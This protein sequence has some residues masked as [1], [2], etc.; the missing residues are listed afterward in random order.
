VGPGLRRARA[1]G[2]RHPETAAALRQLGLLRFQLG[3]YEGAAG[4][5]ERSLAILLGLGSGQ[6][7]KVADGHNNLGE[8]ARVRDRL[9]SAEAHFRL[10]LEAARASL[11]DA[12]PVRL[13]LANNL[14]GL[15]KDVGRLDEAEPLLESG[16]AT[17]EASAADPEALATAR[18]NLAEVR[19]LQGRPA[20][21]APLYARALEEARAALGA[22]H[23]GLVPFLNQAA[24]CEQE[25]G[26]F[27]RA[28]SLFL[29]TGTILRATLGPEH[30][31]LA[32]NLGDLARLRLAAGRPLEADT[33]LARALG[34]RERSL[35]P[36]HP[37]VALIL[38]DRARVRARVEPG[39]EAAPIA[40]ALAILDSS[41]AY[42]DARLDAH[43][44]RAEGEARRGELDAAIADMAVALAWMDSL[45]ARRGGG[46]ETR[47][48]FVSARLPLVDRM[49]DWQLE[50]GA[51]DAALETHERGRARVLLDQIAASGVDLRAGIPPAVL[52]P[53][54]D[55]ERA[56]EARLA[57]AHRGIQ[58][59]RGDPS[60][61]PRER[62]ETLAAL[63]ARRDSA[64]L[65][66]AL[67]RRRIED[68]SPVWRGV[69]SAEGRIPGAA[70]LQRTIV[71]R[72]G[73]LLVYHVGSR[74]GHVFVVPPRGRIEALPL[75]LDPE[76]AAILGVPAGPLADSTLER[77][78]NGAPARDGRAA[79]PGISSLLGGT[80]A[81]GFVALPLRSAA[82][83]DSF[84]LRLNALWR[85]VVPE[86]LRARLRAAR[87]AVVVPDGALHQVAFEALVTRPRGRADATRYWL[88]EGPAV[89]YG[90][91][92]TSLW[93]LA[94]RP[95]RAA[96]R[97]AGRAPVL[98]VSDIDYR[99]SELA[100]AAPPA[101]AGAGAP[102]RGRAWPAL[103]GTARETEA[104]RAAF[105]VGRVEVIT[106]A[107]AR[108]PAVRAAL[109]GRRYLHLA[110]HGF[111]DP[112]GGGLLAG[113]VLAPPP[114]RAAGSD[115]DGVLELFEIHRLPLDCE[116]AVLSACETA[117]GPRIAGEGA[118]ALSRACLAAG[119]RRV[120]ASLWAVD[121]RPTA[122][123]MG[124][125]FEAIAAADARGRAP[126]LARALR[127]AKRR[128]R[129]DP[130][131]ADP[132]HWAPFVL[133]GR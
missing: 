25:L 77:I 67:A 121:D 116:L 21:A 29:E 70:E 99:A 57:A 16:L 127:D 24:V 92:A 129:G 53:L 100:G 83:P 37:D 120:V 89:A 18:L 79:L 87:D 108:E 103:P 19:R 93:S 76:A 38:L 117:K 96:A 51:V 48:A 118:F 123:V 11:A 49:V 55:A 20:Q 97:D 35:G 95:P 109:A 17:L 107:A 61:A 125:L 102:A 110:T 66:L 26:A 115:D 98:S 5:L 86:P 114:A 59:A 91:S 9:D 132:F 36:A 44:L 104:I 23:P 47:A 65:D 105:E 128:V 30:P 56:A 133:S 31:L 10:G 130:R 7:A 106:G 119:A 42:P 81:A 8:L 41:R 122:A 88:D 6:A 33:L 45:R 27:G 82:G 111:A 78:V 58:D 126:H 64:A 3:D 71:P 4:P 113:L 74:E 80:P 22:G 90:P 85:A 60:L 34:L 68:A 32:Q 13:A 63:E 39:S 84:E 15:F 131:W 1:L 12:D 14:A 54:A 101:S 124:A 75:A 52:A 43:A 40:R 62:L 46:D 73:L 50:R 72:D 112:S 69:L 28:D 2:E 94:R